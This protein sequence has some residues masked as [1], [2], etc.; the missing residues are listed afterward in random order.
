[1]RKKTATDR[2]RTRALVYVRKSVVRTG[3]DTVSPERQKAGCLAEAQAHGW[4]VE[5]RDIY[6][7]AE[8][9]RSGRTENRPGW[10]AL[11]RR[12][13]EDET[14]VALI[15]ASLS[16]PS[17]SVRSFLEFVEE[18]RGKGISLVSLKE[19]FDTST[20]MG[21]AMLVF[22]AV[23]NQLEGDLASERMTANIAFKKASGRHWGL[24]PFG[25]KRQGDIKALVP[26]TEVYGENGSERRY[27]DA[28]VRCL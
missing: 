9:H 27:Y 1:V 17:R 19:R 15:V 13:V 18:L 16:R 28:L 24:T 6:T 3:A 23:F 5:E 4:V 21:Q 8:G 11:R 22:V 2:G 12:I 20:A 7:D 25:C 14:I 10:Q 26:S